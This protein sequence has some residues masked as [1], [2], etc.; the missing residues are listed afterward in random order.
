M[1]AGLIALL[2]SME[3]FQT[4]LAGTDEL[5]ARVARLRNHALPPSAPQPIAP[6]VQAGF[7]QAGIIRSQLA[8]PWDHLWQAIEESRSDDVA[9]L[10]VTLDTARGDIG[11]TGEARNFAALSAFA[12]ALAKHDEFDGVTLNQHNL[13]D[14]SPPVVVRFELRLAW[15][16]PAA[17]GT[18]S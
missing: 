1:A 17:A 3:R 15:R 10:S 9:L 8:V 11:L 13:S 5:T 4:E 12:K 2:A 7:H 16:T 18:G 14:G 6:A